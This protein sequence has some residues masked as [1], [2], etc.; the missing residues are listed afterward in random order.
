MHYDHNWGPTFK[1][2]IE[3]LRALGPWDVALGNHPFLSPVDLE[4]VEQQLSRLRQGSGAQGSD[5]GAMHPAVIG[6]A[7]I[8]AFFDAIL[9]IVDEKLVAEPP[10]G[11]PQ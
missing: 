4:V 9:T 3:R 1:K 6:P 5:P 2:S 7:A 8:T 11:P 10:T